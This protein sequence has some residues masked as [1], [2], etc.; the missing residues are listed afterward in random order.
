MHHDTQRSQGGFTLLE[1]LISL[2]IFLAVLTA[3]LSIYEPSHKIYARGER[4][5]DAQDNARLAMG[6]MSRQIRM[7]GYFPENFADPPASPRLA[8]PI[9]VATDQALAIF[10]DADGAGGSSVFLYCLDGQVVRRSLGV[11]DDAD[12]YTCGSGEVVAENVIAL[13]FTYYDAQGD[14][15]PAPPTAPYQLDGQPAG[16]LPS[17]TNVT[18]RASVRRVVITLTAQRLLPGRGLQNYALTSNVWLRNPG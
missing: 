8:L 2:F 13:R 15:V 17:L 18:Q 14:P 6:E 10:G 11:V 5:A 12:S 4:R 1:A 7:A 9:R 3:V 16:S